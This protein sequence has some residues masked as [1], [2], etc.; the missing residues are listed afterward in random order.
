MEPRLTSFKEALAFGKEG[1]AEVA[2]HLINKGYSCLALYQFDDTVAPLIYTSCKNIVSPD[3]LLSN[4]EKTFWVEVKSKRRWSYNYGVKETGFDKRSYNH[5]RNV[6]QLTG[7]NV[8]VVFNHVN[9]EE[10]GMYVASI[11]DEPYR[12]W[13]GINCKTNER[14]SNEMVF[15]HEHQLKKIL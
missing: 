10:S 5:Y 2:E 11:S 7:L 8:Y 4:N 12:I 3:L 6:Y 9:C 14:V 13:D 15:W 1:E